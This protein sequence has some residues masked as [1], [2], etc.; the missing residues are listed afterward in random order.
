MSSDSPT[1]FVERMKASHAARAASMGLTVEELDAQLAREEAERAERNREWEAKQRELREKERIERAAKFRQSVALGFEGRIRDDVRDRIASD[2]LDMSGE[3]G[4]TIV[5][6]WDAAEKPVLILSGGTGT[7]K[8]VAAVEML[9]RHGGSFVHARDLARRHDPW[10]EDRA[11]G[12][13]KI[14]VESRG[15]LVL[16]DLGTE[17]LEDPRFLAAL[18][19]L[20]DARQSV[21]RRTLIT[22][23]LSPAQF[24][25]RYKERF[26]DRL[27]GIA[28]AVTLTGGSMRRSA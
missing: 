12:V 27:N 1:S 23:N 18:E 2:T 8:S 28:K 7:G 11:D 25:E 20:L 4:A 15:L 21:T 17:R 5:S 24:R 26:A 16:D 3:A 10:K 6:W 13:T 9:A 14:D 19:D 22:T